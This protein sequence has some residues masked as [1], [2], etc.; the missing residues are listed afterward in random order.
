MFVVIF[1]ITFV[2]INKKTRINSPSSKITAFM[3]RFPGNVT[4]QRLLAFSR[5]SKPIL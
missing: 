1:F 2:F 5:G 3:F 4:L